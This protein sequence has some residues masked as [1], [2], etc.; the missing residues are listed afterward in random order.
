MG[1][2]SVGTTMP[3]ADRDDEGRYQSTYPLEDF[4]NALE[5]EGGQAGTQD[6]VDRVGCSYELGYKRL[7]SLEDDGQISSQK[8]GNARLW[9]LSGT[10]SDN[11]PN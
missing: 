3:G 8:I 5:A 9:L 11:D 4:I 1:S 2:N 10:D 7:R 6:V